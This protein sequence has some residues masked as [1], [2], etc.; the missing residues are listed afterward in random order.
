MPT[1]TKTEKRVSNHVK[2]RKKTVTKKLDTQIKS[3]SAEKKLVSNSFKPTGR[4]R[5]TTTHKT[6]TQKKLQ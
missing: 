3:Q 2:T 1:K 6:T 4:T 5:N